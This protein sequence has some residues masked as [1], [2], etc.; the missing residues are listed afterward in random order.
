MAY[1]EHW[2]MV[3]AKELVGITDFDL[4]ATLVW[5]M[6]YGS[7]LFYKPKR[8]RGLFGIS[9]VHLARTL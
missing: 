1:R 6:E 2:A 4:S 5:N 7:G 3:V 8:S 9:P